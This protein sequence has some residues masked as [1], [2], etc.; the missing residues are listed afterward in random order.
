MVLFIIPI[1]LKI[2]S[3]GISDHSFVISVVGMHILILYS[4]LA[5]KYPSM[6]MTGFAG[7]G[8]ILNLFTFFFPTKIILSSSDD[9]RI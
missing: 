7:E 1:I 4:H 3:L 9:G 8:F 6:I 5:L 2:F